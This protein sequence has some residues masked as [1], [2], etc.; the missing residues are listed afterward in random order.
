MSTKVKGAVILARRAFIEDE[1][2]EGGWKQV[3]A[4]VPPEYRELLPGLILSTQ[5]LPFEVNDALDRVIVEVVGKGDRSVFKRIGA[6]SARE[7]L[8]GPHRHFL[9]PGDPAAFMKRT[10]RIYRFYYDQGHRDFEFTSE[11]SG[12]MTTYDAETFS[13]TDCLT[14]IGWYEEALAM[15]GAST[16]EMTEEECRADGAPHCRYRVSWRQ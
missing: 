14:V 11:T 1:L 7:N 15:C 6:R 2:G 16:V 3:L 12:V 4:A 13:S 9:S 5:W 10:E 8:G